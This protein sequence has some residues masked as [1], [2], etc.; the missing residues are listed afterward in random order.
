[1]GPGS[2][3]G[4]GRGFRAVE[5]VRRTR[6]DREELPK[7]AGGFRPVHGTGRNRATTTTGIAPRRRRIRR[8]RA[9]TEPSNGSVLQG[10]LGGGHLGAPAPVVRKIWSHGSP[11]R[12]RFPTLV[13]SHHD[14]TK[15]LVSQGPEHGT[16]HGCWCRGDRGLGNALGRRGGKRAFEYNQGPRPAGTLLGGLRPLVVSSSS[17]GHGN[18]ASACCPFRLRFPCVR[19]GSAGPARWPG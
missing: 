1:M 12:R 5:L 3:G 2:V 7:R 14:A 18:R 16:V 13:R 17:A 6:Q 11:K 9:R 19:A 4:R 8:R 15:S 10:L